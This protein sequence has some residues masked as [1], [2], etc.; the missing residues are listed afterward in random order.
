MQSIYAIGRLFVTLILVGSSVSSAYASVVTGPLTG[1]LLLEAPA[2]VGRIGESADVENATT[3]TAQ[4]LFWSAIPSMPS[5]RIGHGSVMLGNSLLVVGGYSATSTLQPVVNVFNVFSNTWSALK[6]IPT[7]RAHLGV[8]AVNGKAYAIGGHLV[9]P[10]Y[11]SVSA[12]EMYDPT[13]NDWITK[14]AMPSAQ[15]NFAYATGANNRIYV[16]GGETYTTSVDVR[17]GINNVLEYDPVGDSWQSRAAMSS[18][19]ELAAAATGSDGKI[20]VTG[21]W[22]RTGLSSGERLSSMEVFD[23]ATNTWSVAAPMPQSRTSHMAF[24]YGDSI[25]VVGGE[26]DASAAQ[27]TVYEYVIATNMWHTRTNF[28][29]N[30]S[31]AGVAVLGDGQIFLTGG[32]NG[33][34]WYA[35]ASK[36]IASLS[37][38]PVASV[39]DARW[40]QGAAEVNGKIYIVGGRNTTTYLTATHRLNLAT[41]AW[42]TVAPIPERVELAATVSISGLLYV[43]GGYSPRTLNST[44]WVQVYNPTTNLWYTRTNMPTA[45]HG[46]AGVVGINGKIYAMGGGRQSPVTGYPLVEEYDPVT[47][48][49]QSKANI[50]KTSVGGAA[51][52]TLPNGEIVYMGGTPG[53][54]I[55][56]SVFVYS[57]NTNVWITS[58][59]MST[60]RAYF[61]AG[62]Y[63]NLLF[64]TG[65]S[66]AGSGSGGFTRDVLAYNGDTRTWQSHSLLS[67]VRSHVS[68]VVGSDGYLYALS[69]GTG[70]SVGGNI[71]E[72]AN[73]SSVDCLLSTPPPAT[74]FDGV[75]LDDQSVQQV[76]TSGAPV[77]LFLRVRN[78]G[79]S[80]W[81]AGS[82][83]WI[84]GNEWSGRTVTLTTTVA[85][86]ETVMLIQETFNAPTQP[87]L[88]FYTVQMRNATGTPFGQ[89]FLLRV[90]VEPPATDSVE[91]VDQS[92]QQTVKPGVP[93]NLF[94]RVRNTGT[95]TWAAGS[96]SWI[97]GNEWSGRSG[98]LTTTV[99][100]SETLTLI[101]ETFNAPTQPGLYFYTVQMR[102]ATGS[103]FGQQFLLR[104]LVEPSATAAV[105][106]VDQSVQQ[107]V[108]PGA[109]VSLFL[110]VRNTGTSTWVAG[111]YGWVGGNAWAGRS[112]TLTTTVAPSETVT[113]IQETFNAP[114]QPGLYSYTVQL[115]DASGLVFGQ[116]FPLHILV[117]SAGVAVLVHGW[118]GIPDLVSFTC[119]DEINPKPNMPGRND[120]FGRIYDL[121]IQNGWHV[122]F[123][124]YTTNA[125]RTAPIRESAEC[126]S[127]RIDAI[128]KQEPGRKLTIIAHSMGGIVAR[129]YLDG[130][131][132]SPPQS[133]WQ[134]IDRLITLGSPHWGVNIA[135]LNRLFQLPLVIS[136]LV[137]ISI[138]LSNGGCWINPGTCDL[139]TEAADR[140]NQ[141]Y[142]PYENGKYHFIGGSGS[143]ISGTLQPWLQ[144]RSV[145]FEGGATDGFIGQRSATGYKRQTDES[146]GMP[147]RYETSATHLR[148]WG[149]G[150]SYFD[151]I[152][153]ECVLVNLLEFRKHRAC[154]DTPA[155]KAPKRTEMPQAIADTSLP[156]LADILQ[157][158]ASKTYNLVIDGS[159]MTL[160]LAWY[161]GGLEMQLT[162]PSGV[163][164]TKDSLATLMPSAIASSS[165]S[166]D[167]LSSLGFIIPMPQ[168]GIWQVTIRSTHNTIS[169][170]FVLLGG[171][172]SS[173]GLSVD[174]IVPV[175]SGSPATVLVRL[176]DDGKPLAGATV[177]ASTATE[178]GVITFKLAEVAPGTY[179]G[180]S[181]IIGQ[182]GQYFVN[183][184]ASGTTPAAYQRQSSALL[185]IFAPDTGLSVSATF[186]ALNTDNIAGLDVLRLAVPL[187]LPATGRYAITLEIVNSIGNLISAT[188]YLM[189]APPENIT[190]VLDLPAS[191]IRQKRFDGPYHASIKIVSADLTTAFARSDIA[192]SIAFKVSDFGTGHY[193]YLPMIRR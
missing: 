105:A 35:T 106:L 17:W 1:G 61:F 167:A 128:S 2:S 23:P 8:A 38:T 156:S 122:Y 127:R 28:L 21:G 94:L 116:P 31:K 142:P 126:L 97:G 92:A 146:L 7:P 48:S 182:P 76:A 154:P 71:V 56:S 49:W 163:T 148:S 9:N 85:P 80:T 150:Q 86:S 174:P 4:N 102:N 46:V 164:Y 134:A 20:Y 74:P 187:T 177:T 141:L 159:E 191:L 188:Q 18:G 37:W 108:K 110:R 30:I 166:T 120:N 162:S 72:R 53:G 70:Y 60:G 63:G 101:Q 43:I 75:S 117:E 98:T 5:M 192:Q 168:V 16:F 67:S 33:S 55:F 131:D 14:T 104:V 103:P 145:N 50:P 6:S 19:R 133:K 137:S 95:S 25:V 42:E 179:V 24:A 132:G 165:V 64:T 65:G 185:E 54:T 45:R 10:L 68:T 82:Y 90:L 13:L 125:I 181:N 121:L 91:L 160:L 149:N 169:S 39:P 136:P 170:S 100:P 78:T 99:A 112:S 109:P 40:G 89:Q 184:E 66:I 190:L 96:Y 151:S 118:Q 135:F 12:V 147:F 84:G 15:H 47:D 173:V 111:S 62:A 144:N 32:A 158:G 113:L 140:R 171:V 93:V 175:A 87:G 107:T 27:A 130:S 69:G 138:S 183:V 58:T 176:T 34:T 59:S 152:A 22:A 186:A 11:Q 155:A 180:S 153:T 157:P 57:P 88:Y 119:D 44:N 139:S 83:G 129:Q 193:V 81:A 124:H 41:Q 161:T 3:C 178:S 29:N 115:R 77:S 123:A 73:L 172:Q 189:S 114:T 26:N 36:G 52:A 79:T 51:V 143:N